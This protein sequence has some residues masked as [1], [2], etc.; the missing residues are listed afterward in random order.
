[1]KEPEFILEEDELFAA[2]RNGFYETV[3]C[4]LEQ[5]YG[6][7]FRIAWGKTF[8]GESEGSLSIRYHIKEQ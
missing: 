4:L 2:F 5:K 3:E 7:D 1:M 8:E 6:E